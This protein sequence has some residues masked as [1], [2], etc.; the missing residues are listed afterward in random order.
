[1]MASKTKEAVGKVSGIKKEAPKA[2]KTKIK[3][4]EMAEWELKF[5]KALK[6]FNSDVM[7]D[8]YKDIQVLTD[9]TDNFNSESEYE[10]MKSEY[11][12]E[13]EAI[14]KRIQETQEYER[15]KKLEDMIRDQKKVISIREKEKEGNE[16]VELTG[17]KNDL[18][19]MTDEYDTIEAVISGLLRKSK[20]I[21]NRL[22]RAVFSG[23]GSIIRNRRLELNMSLKNIEELTG[24]SPSY[25]NRIEKGQRK[26][27]SYGIIE[28]LAE[29]LNLPVSKLTNVP[30]SKT[31]ES[32]SD[33]SLQ[34]MIL[35]S[36][37]T[38][39]GKKVSKESKEKMVDMINYI[40]SMQWEDTT[41]YKEIMPIM[42]FLDYFKK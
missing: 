22:Q 39:N 12:G 36:K 20:V 1:M 26:A 38:L 33:L 35:S 29:A 14:E 34:E 16:T 41:K 31:D 2:K 5:T 18:K 3:K 37:F 13:L 23:F 15:M 30:K 7:N 17:L 10:D 40:S 28:Q 24:I 27:P 25:I 8:I 21:T 42:E 4:A 19:I 32:G 9:K 11:S 6:E